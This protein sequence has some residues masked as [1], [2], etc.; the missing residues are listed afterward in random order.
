MAA[1]PTPRVRVDAATDL[2]GGCGSSLTWQ[3]RTPSG[4][5]DPFT[6]P[7]PQTEADFAT[8]GGGTVVLPSEMPRRDPSQPR[9]QRVGRGRAVTSGTHT[10]SIAS[11]EPYARV[12]A[13]AWRSG[14]H[15]GDT[16][17]RRKTKQQNDRG[18]WSGTVSPPRSPCRQLALNWERVLC[19]AVPPFM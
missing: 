17:R 11:S 1:T 4:Q 16:M 19:P 14:K 10:A 12:S 2:D 15:G 13:A 6:V 7:L 9:Q 3:Q 5:V 18:I 8:V